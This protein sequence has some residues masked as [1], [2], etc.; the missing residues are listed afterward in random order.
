M[1]QLPPKPRARK[2]RPPPRSGGDGAVAPS[3]LSSL[4]AAAA[5]P[6]RSHAGTASYSEICAAVGEAATAAACAPPIGDAATAAGPS[7]TQVPA[8]AP[9]RCTELAEPPRHL[10]PARSTFGEGEP[11]HV[12]AAEALVHAHMLR[13]RAQ[14]KLPVHCWSATPENAARWKQ[15]RPAPFRVSGFAARALKSSLLV[16][17]GG[18]GA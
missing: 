12:A 16:T 9:G 15:A 18:K 14:R 7:G 2:K 17:P 6:R 1:D 8:M 13:W 3:A 10:A 5:R 4:A 11:L